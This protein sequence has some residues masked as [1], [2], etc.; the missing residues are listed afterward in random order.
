MIRASRRVAICAAMVGL[1]IS[2]VACDEDP[3]DP[4][5]AGRDAQT[6]D[7]GQDAG[8]EPVDSGPMED[9]GSDAGPPPVNVR[10]AHLI[11]NVPGTMGA[12]HLCLAATG[13][14]SQLLIT[15]DAAGAVAPIPYGGVSPYTDRLTLAPIS[16]TVFVYEVADVTG[17][18]CPAT[19]E[20]LFSSEVD[21]SLL[22]GGSTYTIAA[23]GRVGSTG[24][25][26]PG[27]VIIEDDNADPAAD[28]TRLRIVHAITGVPVNVDICFDPD[29]PT[30]A[31]PGELI[32]ADV[33]FVGGATT[34]LD[35]PY[36]ERDPIAAGALLIYARAA[37]AVDCA[38]P[39]GAPTLAFPIP[40]P[41]PSG[42]GIPANI[43]A[44]IDADD[45][46]TVFLR[47]D[48][49]T[50]GT[51]AAIPCDDGGTACTA[52]GG[53]C[54]TVA[55]GTMRCLHP[56]GPSLTP[57]IDNLPPAAP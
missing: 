25:S 17:T 49:P 3:D 44:T 18:D 33:A 30:M 35:L 40:F 37:G 45:V 9:A 53:A 5:D 12:V 21:A 14:T 10:L 42:A 27:L 1:S 28:M 13:T 6:A 20:A 29:G 54:T 52:G 34:V 46:V 15:R 4:V 51:A 50:G 22:A 2:L 19:T 23:V 57:W 48:A 8:T 36:D 56:Q 39:T 11:A 16:Y 55:P 7:A 41:V 26:A 31:M 24:A 43:T 38:A 47:G 32:A